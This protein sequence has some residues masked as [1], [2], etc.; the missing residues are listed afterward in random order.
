MVSFFIRRTDLKLSQTEGEG[1]EGYGFFTV[2]SMPP[3]WSH[4]G[5]LKGTAAMEEGHLPGPQLPVWDPKPKISKPGQG[6]AGGCIERQDFLSFVGDFSLREADRPISAHSLPL[7]NKY[8]LELRLVGLHVL[9]NNAPEYCPSCS[10][11]ALSPGLS[12]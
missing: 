7:R 2:T 5:L 1:D 11:L 3:S 8:L 9:R 12:I 10:L 4:E 6:H